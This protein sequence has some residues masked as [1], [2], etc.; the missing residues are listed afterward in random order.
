ME[1]SA[2]LVGLAWLAAINVAAW[3]AFAGDKRAATRGA[4]RTPERT[5]LLLALLGGSPA[6]IAAQRILRHKTRKQPFATL[7]ALIALAQGAAVAA[8]L[9]WRAGLFG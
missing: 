3:I 5:L 2:L 6:A 8:A 7:L 1:S 4:G 9:A